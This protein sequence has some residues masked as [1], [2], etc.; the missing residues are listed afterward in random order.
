MIRVE[1]Q[2]FNG[3][4]NSGKMLQNVKTAISRFENKFEFVETLVEDQ[5]AA[6]QTKFRGSPTLLINGIDFEN[7]DVPEVPSL[8]C[9]Y[10]VNGVP[11]QEEIFNEI[12]RVLN[13]TSG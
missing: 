4:P 10:Y 12:N 13:E 8:A 7:L 9:R 6:V 3:C 1:V 2:Y 11:T 5:E